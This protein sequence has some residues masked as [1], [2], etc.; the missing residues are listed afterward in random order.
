[1]TAAARA[2]LAGDEHR[3]RVR[4]ARLDL[5]PGPRHRGLHDV[6][7]QDGAP[8]RR[9]GRRL[10]DQQREVERLRRVR[11]RAHGDP[12]DARLRDRAH[13]LRGDAAR[14]LEQDARSRA[15]REGD[16]LA[17]LG[18]R[19]V[20]EEHEAR[21]GGER[22]LELRP[23]PHLDLDEGRRRPALEPFA[24]P[25]ERRRHAPRRPHVVLLQENGVEQPGAVVRPAARAD[26]L[27]L[28]L[29]PSRR[30]LA[31]V[32]DRR[33]GA[34]DR[35]H[36][37]PRERRHA[38]EPGEE[39]QRE[40]LAGQ[41]GGE[42]ALEHRDRRAGREPLAVPQGPPLA[43]L[44][45]EP[46]EDPRGRGGPAE[47]SL[48]ARDD[49]RAAARARR[50]GELGRE[51]ARAHVLAQ[52]GLEQRPDRGRGPGVGLHARVSQARNSAPAPQQ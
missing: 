33:P 19:E 31:G 22:L 8:E 11:E 49:P 51:V 41:D 46:A 39:V 37:R 29:P 44:R 40:P 32:E 48:L 12:V 16:G 43:E 15:P 17:Q 52:R 5:A 47:H 10:L 38:R 35:V 27:A 6:P 45:V 24:N 4:G 42:R 9:R 2:L 21:A 7:P 26:R 13:G 14:G 36:A 18:E 23:V 28:E 34:G 1:V 20:V 3:A 50:D 25:L 30:R